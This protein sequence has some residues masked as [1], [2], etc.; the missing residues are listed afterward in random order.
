VPAPNL[1][2]FRISLDYGLFPANQ[3][4]EWHHS[5]G[6]TVKTEVK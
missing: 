5:I 6:S 3:V 4:V 1:S 2:G